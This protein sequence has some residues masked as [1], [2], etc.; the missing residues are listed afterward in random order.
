MADGKW[1]GGLSRDMPAV[2]AA[3]RVLEV[4]LS[5]VHERLAPAVEH[6]DE[7]VEH[8]HQLRV[9]TRRAAAALRIF[10]TLLPKSACRKVRK[11]LRSIR[12]AAGAARDWDVFLEEILA[13]LTQAPRTHRR[14]LEALLGIG[15]GERMAAQTVLVEAAQDPHLDLPTLTSETLAALRPH[16]RDLTLGEL[17]EALL[18]QLVEELTQA[19][20]EDL[21]DYGKLHRVRI[22]GKRLRYALEV[23][24][25]CFGDDFRDQCYPAIEKM[26]DILG[27]ANDSH[28]A[29]GRLAAIQE[30]LQARAPE[31]WPRFRPAVTALVKE[32]QQRL[33]RQRALFLEWWRDWHDSGTLRH[34]TRQLRA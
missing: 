23:F 3:Q 18:G 30:V 11:R 13:R 8:V 33:P 22:V 28:V 31:R 17:G 19:A 34:M 10:D 4:R 20:E 26:Q 6:A 5:A 12:Q 9:S 16:R 1:I 25:A 14:G 2:A 7:D 15:L 27:Q 24:A 21:E 32:H 29:L